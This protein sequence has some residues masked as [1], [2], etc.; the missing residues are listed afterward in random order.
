M[1]HCVSGTFFI[2]PLKSGPNNDPDSCSPSS[3][4]LGGR[5]HGTRLML[6]NNTTVQNFLRTFSNQ[7]TIHPALSLRRL[8]QDNSYTEDLTHFSQ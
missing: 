2:G 6:T 8:S 7:I 3:S 1:Y 5:A 4:W